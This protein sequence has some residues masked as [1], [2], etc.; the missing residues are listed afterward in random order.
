MEIGKILLT[1]A[2]IYK[3]KYI[4]INVKERNLSWEG[5][6]KGGRNTYTKLIYGYNVFPSKI[7]L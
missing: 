6:S 5:G 7:P 2:K 4:G 1:V 3:K